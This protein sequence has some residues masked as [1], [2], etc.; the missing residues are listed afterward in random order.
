MY[1]LVSRGVESIKQASKGSWVQ[2]RFTF[3]R[4]CRATLDR[5]SLSYIL[6]TAASKLLVSRT[7]RRI[8]DPASTLHWLDPYEMLARP[9]IR[10]LLSYAAL[11]LTV[12]H[13][14]DPTFL[15]FHSIISWPTWN[16]ATHILQ[17]FFSVLRIPP[18]SYSGIFIIYS[19][20]FKI[21]RCTFITPKDVHLISV[22]FFLLSLISAH[23]VF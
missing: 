4:A 14:F 2:L 11:L 18:I 21:Q 1:R 17:T 6:A 23:F 16:H 22:I 3:S 10:A 7:S 20:F 8:R 5:S 13:A 12:S 15:S 9:P 19:I